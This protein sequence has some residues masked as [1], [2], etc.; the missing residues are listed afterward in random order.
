MTLPL[1]AAIDDAL[2]QREV[3]LHGLDRAREHSDEEQEA[4][5]EYLLGTLDDVLA[6]VAA[7]EARH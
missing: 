7:Q 1:N 6:I 3:L 5:L 4:R 2:R